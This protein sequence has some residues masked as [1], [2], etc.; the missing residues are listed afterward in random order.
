MSS[1]VWLGTLRALR[2]FNRIARTGGVIQIQFHLN[3]PIA[4]DAVSRTMNITRVTELISILACIRQGYMVAPPIF[5]P[6]SSR[7]IPSSH[8]RRWA[9][10]DLTVTIAPAYARP[11]EDTL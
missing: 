6:S 5:E 3:A 7:I 2:K 9:Q 11:V 10:S 4:S 8:L 1:G